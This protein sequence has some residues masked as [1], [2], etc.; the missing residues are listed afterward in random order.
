MEL[1]LDSTALSSITKFKDVT[2]AKNAGVGKKEWA[3]D[4]SFEKIDSSRYIYIYTHK[5]YATVNYS[6]LKNCYTDINLINLSLALH[7][8]IISS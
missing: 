8:A 3:P 7:I 5:M 4:G 6:Q 1:R 2:D